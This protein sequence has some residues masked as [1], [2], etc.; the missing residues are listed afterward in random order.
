MVCQMLSPNKIKVNNEIIKKSN[1][2]SPYTTITKFANS[3]S[4]SPGWLVTREYV[5][6]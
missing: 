5:K 4:L 2:A 3:K 6:H 1:Y